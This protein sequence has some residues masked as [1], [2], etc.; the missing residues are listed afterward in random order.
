MNSISSGTD[1][2]DNSDDSFVSLSEIDTNINTEMNSEQ[3]SEPKFTNLVDYYNRPLSE[4]F[5]N[6]N[7]SRDEVL[8]EASIALNHFHA[9]LSEEQENQ[10]YLTPSNF[11]YVMI[12]VSRIENQGCA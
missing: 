5:R 4:Q 7:I 1:R 10:I 6:L 3:G 2:S 8:K 12:I 11:R 9:K